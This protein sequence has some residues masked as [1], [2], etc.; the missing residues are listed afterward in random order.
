MGAT[1]PTVA[2]G[3]TRDGSLPSERIGKPQKE[4]TKTVA[5]YCAIDDPVDLTNGDGSLQTRMAK[6]CVTYTEDY[7][8]AG[9]NETSHFVIARATWDQKEN[10]VLA[11]N[12]AGGVLRTDL[13]FKTV[14]FR[15]FPTV[16]YIDVDTGEVSRTCIT[17]M[18]GGP[19]PKVKLQS[20][21]PLLDNVDSRAR[22]EMTYRRMAD[23]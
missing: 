8:S 16:P 18:T 21:A 19:S 15:T 3:P 5:T 10:H 20:N 14:F 2:E 9:R 12:G 13:K 22:L 11:T 17:G 7:E 1:A 6:L 23:C 4:G